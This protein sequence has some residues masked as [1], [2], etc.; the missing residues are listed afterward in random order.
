MMDRRKGNKTRLFLSTKRKKHHLRIKRKIHFAPCTL[1]SKESREPFD[2][3]ASS[4]SSTTILD[5]LHLVCDDEDGDHNEE[6]QNDKLSGRRIVDIKYLFSA[7]S[8]NI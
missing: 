8:S 1:P 4:S 2:E 5:D 3:N 7:I 6:I